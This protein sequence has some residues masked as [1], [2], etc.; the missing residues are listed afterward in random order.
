MFT[1]ESSCANSG[2]PV[3]IELDSNSNILGVAESA[4]PMFC[5]ALINTARTKEPSIVDIF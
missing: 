5:V 3:K 1:I 4:E 2:K